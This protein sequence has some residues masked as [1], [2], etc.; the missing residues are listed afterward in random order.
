MPAM[1]ATAKFILANTSISKDVLTIVQKFLEPD[2]FKRFYP[3]FK[4]VGK[5]LYLVTDPKSPTSMTNEKIPLNYKELKD[6]SKI[7]KAKRSKIM[8]AFF[9]EHVS[10]LRI[11]VYLDWFF[12]LPELYNSGEE[13]TIRYA[14]K[15]R[16][17]HVSLFC[18]IMK[19]IV[20]K[21]N[22]DECVIVSPSGRI[23]SQGIFKIEWLK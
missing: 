23:N 11:S 8:K 6:F 13:F 19:D 17:F 4:H 22:K 14:S 18:A 1:S 7:S 9:D 16:T 15:C 21:I 12:K 10:S 5:R 20:K 3:L 2:Y